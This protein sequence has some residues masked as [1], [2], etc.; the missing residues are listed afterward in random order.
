MQKLALFIVALVLVLH[1]TSPAKAVM[2]FQ[3]EFMKLYKVDKDAPEQTEFSKQVL[4][5]KC[6]CCH[7]G[8]KSKKNRNPYGT[9]LAKLLDRKTDAKNPEKIIEALEKVAKMHT[10]PKDDKSPTYGD[11]I[12][13]GKLPGGPLEE[14]KKEP[15]PKE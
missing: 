11:L 1:A 10:D 9:E 14:A 3:N 2:Q 8:R 12:K 4:E 15:E 13:E 6:F 5:A 7:Q